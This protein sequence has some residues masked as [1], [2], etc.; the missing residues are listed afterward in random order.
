MNPILTHL[1]ETLSICEKAT[2]GPWGKCYHAPNLITVDASDF[3]GSIASVSRWMTGV[4]G[5]D[6]ENKA[7]AEF[8]A[9]ARTHYPA[10][11]RALKV[12]VESVQDWVE[13][14]ESGEPSDRADN[15]RYA[16]NLLNQIS[17]LLGLAGKGVE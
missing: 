14:W 5:D 15:I 1:D 16:K 2:P 13:D 8:I 9:A 4:P 12:A 6:S 11:L 3:L 7:N 17:A 10:A